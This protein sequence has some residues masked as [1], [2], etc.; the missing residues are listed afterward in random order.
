MLSQIATNAIHATMLALSVS[1]HPCCLGFCTTDHNLGRKLPSEGIC[2]SFHNIEEHLR[3]SS[4]L[5]LMAV[6][7][8]LP[9]MLHASATLFRCNPLNKLKHLT[10]DSYHSTI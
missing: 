7:T 8:G 1:N 6:R 5:C 2:E 9:T 3:H 4:A 10:T